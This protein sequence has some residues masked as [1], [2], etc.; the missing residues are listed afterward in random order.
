MSE[1]DLRPLMRHWPSGVTVVTSANAAQE[2]LSGMTVSTFTSLSL[3]PPLIS[4]F[5]AKDT[6][7]AECILQ[8]KVFAVSILSEHQ[9]ELSIRFAGY[10]PSF[11]EPSTRFEG[12]DFDTGETGAPLLIGTL[13]WFDCKLWAA[14]DGSTHHIMVGEVVGMSQPGEIDCKPLVYYNGGYHRL[15]D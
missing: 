9:Q 11:T 15:A 12:L 2:E 8:S 7:T 1:L 13:G 4:V 10:D 3:E 5:L 6:H 14:Y